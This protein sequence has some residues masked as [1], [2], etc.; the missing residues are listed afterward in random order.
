MCSAETIVSEKGCIV[1]IFSFESDKSTEWDSVEGILRTWF[2][3]SEFFEFG[4]DAYA[5]FQDFHTTELGC[6][7]VSEF[8]DDYQEH[9]YRYADD[10]SE[11]M[12]C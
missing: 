6:R 12:I 3:L 9:K 10:D 11:H 1:G 8:M 2:V 7:E 5:K 4:W